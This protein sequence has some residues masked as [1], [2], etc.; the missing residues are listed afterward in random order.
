MKRILKWNVSVNDRVTEIGAGRVIHIGCQD[1]PDVVQ[2][3]T[4]ESDQRK[5]RKRK[6]R[7]VA[8]GE[9]YDDECVALGSVVYATPIVGSLVWTVISF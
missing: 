7:V 1:G 5:D 9:P 6:V 3:W 4:E 2:V 8:T